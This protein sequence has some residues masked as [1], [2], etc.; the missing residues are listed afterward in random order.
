MCVLC[1]SRTLV[2]ASDPDAEYGST[3]LEY[4]SILC[5]QIQYMLDVSTSQKKDDVELL[6]TSVCSAVLCLMI[7][8]HLPLLVLPT[9]YKAI[10]C[11][12]SLS[13]PRSPVHREDLPLWAPNGLGFPGRRRQKP[14]G[15]LEPNLGPVRRS[16]NQPQPRGNR[17][18][19]AGCSAVPKARPNRGHQPNCGATNRLLERRTGSKAAIHSCAALQLTTS[20][21]LTEKD[22]TGMQRLLHDALLASGSRCMRPR[23]IITHRL[24][25]RDAIALPFSAVFGHSPR[26]ASAR[27]AYLS[28]WRFFRAHGPGP[29]SGSCALQSFCSFRRKC[30]LWLPT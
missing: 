6:S 28:A 1:P 2:F 7:H 18:T 11:L 21:C 3:Q 24:S 12:V 23:E 8:R 16:S 15:P 25:G 4:S 5:G 19:V 30:A 29:S 27:F 17:P 13:I 22:C 9:R 26:R 20:A 10:H 14:L